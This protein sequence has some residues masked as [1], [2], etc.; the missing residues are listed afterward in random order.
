[1][2]CSGD[3]GVEISDFPSLD[4]TFVNPADERRECRDPLGSP[5]CCL[6][7]GLKNI[8]VISWKTRNPMFS[9]SDSKL[10]VIFSVFLGEMTIRCLA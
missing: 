4:F 6:V 1:M 5:T 3:F 7:I 9:L 10:S 8:Q 2:K